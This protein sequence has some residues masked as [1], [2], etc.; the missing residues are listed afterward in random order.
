MSLIFPE[1]QAAVAMRTCLG[2]SVPFRYSI[3][4]FWSQ[5]YTVIVTKVL[6]YSW[7]VGI[8]AAPTLFFSASHMN[9]RLSVLVLETVLIGH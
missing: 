1:N 4:L 8:V 5:S 2:S 7:K 9:A 6:Q 3:C